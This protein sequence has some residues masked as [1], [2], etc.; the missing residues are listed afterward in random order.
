MYA[1][2]NIS[3]FEES[4]IYPS[5]L[6]I[7]GADSKMLDFY[8]GLYI[9]LDDHSFPRE[10][11]SAA[12]AR[13]DVIIGENNTLDLSFHFSGEHS[14]KVNFSPINASF[15]SIFKRLDDYFLPVKEFRGVSFEISM[16]KI[17]DIR[18]FV[19]PL[20]TEG[21]SRKAKLE[22]FH[23]F[24]QGTLSYILDI[25]QDFATTDQILTIF[26]RVPIT[27]DLIAYLYG[28]FNEQEFYDLLVEQKT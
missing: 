18:D 5:V 4:N 6:T 26:Q 12:Y 3:D 25:F 14:F 24:I 1:I 2:L 16:L 20:D 13:Y 15:F 11:V 17:H 23:R 21:E 7:V 10:Y 19:Y 22:E 8:R 27:P 28:K 9:A